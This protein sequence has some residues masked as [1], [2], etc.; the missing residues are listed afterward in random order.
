M[1]LFDA[2]L[3]TRLNLL[4]WRLRISSAYTDKSLDP[5]QITNYSHILWIEQIPI[6][7]RLVRGQNLTILNHKMRV[8]CTVFVSQ[9]A[10]TLYSLCI[11]TTEFFSSV[12]L[13]CQR[14]Y[15]KNSFLSCALNNQLDYSSLVYTAFVYFFILNG[16]FY[17]AAHMHTQ[18]DSV[19]SFVAK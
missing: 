6:Y 17:W 8:H 10:R 16:F 4:L 15:I 13:A 2:P 11:F 3:E 12:G 19:K 7:F 1:G 14:L 5:C 18:R 9:D